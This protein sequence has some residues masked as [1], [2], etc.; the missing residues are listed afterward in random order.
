[1][2]VLIGVDR[3]KGSHTAV[4]IELGELGEELRRQ[5]E[6]LEAV[7]GLNRELMAKLNSS[8]L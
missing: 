1:M 7:R 6:G 5:G 8:R 3:H 4:A 2:K